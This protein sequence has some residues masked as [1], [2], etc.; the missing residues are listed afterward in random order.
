[1][2]RYYEFA[3]SATFGVLVE[4]WRGG[5][6]FNPPVGWLIAAFFLLATVLSVPSWLGNRKGLREKRDAEKME[7]WIKWLAAWSRQKRRENRFFHIHVIENHCSLLETGFKVKSSLE[8]LQTYIPRGGFRPFLDTLHHSKSND[9]VRD[10][11]CGSIYYGVDIDK[12]LPTIYETC[13]C[14]NDAPVDHPEERVEPQ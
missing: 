10:Y 13:K 7:D 14:E 11:Y 2:T 5:T 1:M 12:N 8:S 6:V 3:L 4:T 9:I